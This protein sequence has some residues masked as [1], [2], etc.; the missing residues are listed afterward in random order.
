MCSVMAAGNEVRACTV[1]AFSIFITWQLSGAEYVTPSSDEYDFDIRKFLNSSEKIWTLNTTSEKPQFCK[2]DL[3]RNITEQEIFF[4]RKSNGREE[5]LHG[6]FL[7]NRAFN[8]YSEMNVGQT[9][10]LLDREEIVFHGYNNTCA[11]F[12]TTLLANDIIFFSFNQREIVF[13]LRVKNSSVHN[14]DQEC[15]EQFFGYFAK[16]KKTQGLYFNW[17]QT[18]RMS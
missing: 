12:Q 4:T 5:L 18:S 13:E 1:I 8:E 16:G 7:Y 10:K 11:V 15:L 2:S 3:K 17:C 6:E 14:P 9:G